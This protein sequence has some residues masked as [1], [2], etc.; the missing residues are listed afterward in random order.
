MR[1]L[2]DENIPASVIA[3]LR[4]LG[5]DIEWVRVDAP[6][7]ADATIL[8]RSESENRILLTFDKDFGELAFHEVRRQACGIILLR[9]MPTSP[10]DAAALI[11]QSLSAR[12]DWA[13][14][15]SVVEPGRVRMRPLKRPAVRPGK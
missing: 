12:T 4:D 9:F 1:L 8:A 6:G 5:H 3:R 10:V 7:A 14:Y 2:A 13:G 15:F 11:A